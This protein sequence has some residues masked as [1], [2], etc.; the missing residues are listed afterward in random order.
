MLRRTAQ[1]GARRGRELWRCVD[2]VCPGI[3]D[4]EPDADQ[5]PAPGAGE[6]AQ[7]RFE[8]ERA[9]HAARLRRGAPVIASV[10]VLVA[11]AMF[12]GAA[13]LVPAPIAA[14]L[15][16]AVVGVA[17]W[18]VL[19]LPGDV[20]SWERGA[21]AERR[22]GVKL[23]GLAAAGFVTLYDRRFP[24]RG[25]NIDA[26]T[27][28]PPGVFVVETKFRSAGIEIINGQLHVGGRDRPELIGQVVDEA[29]RVQVSLAPEMNRHRLT[30]V[31]VLCF[32]NRRVKGGDRSA[33]VLIVDESHVAK[34]LAEMPG[35]LG[36]EGVQELA[37]QIDRA[38]PRNDR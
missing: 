34:R 7:A 20:I 15:A 16:I 10:G 29:L 35:V 31:P 33:G 38:L 28:G 25:G 11:A 32:V 5:M 8:S 13:A 21:E 18:S 9:A 2:R 23:D 26:I 3:I 19:K 14:L 1:Q 6:S 12:F 22:V 36:S 24:G 4:I 17:F 27:V 37:R 30:V